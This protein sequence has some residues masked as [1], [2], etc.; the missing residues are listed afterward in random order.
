MHLAWRYIR[1]EGSNTCPGAQGAQRLALLGRF[2]AL[3]ALAVAAS[4]IALGRPVDQ[5]LE[6]LAALRP[7][8][9]RMQRLG[10]CGMP[11]VVV[12]YAHTP[13]ALEQVLCAL[14]PVATQRRGRLICVVGAGGERDTGKR[15]LMG[16][17]AARHADQ[18]C[19]SSDNPRGENP[20]H[21]IAQMLDG[22]RS[23][24]GTG[25]PGSAA[26]ALGSGSVSALDGT[27]DACGAACA[28]RS[29]R[30][31]CEADRAT[32]IDRMLA[33]AAR[34][35]LVLIAGKGHE[36]YQEIGGQRL[37]FDDRKEAIAGLV[38]HW[39]F[40]PAQDAVETAAH[41]RGIVRERRTVAR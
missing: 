27:A 13:D 25:T 33:G 16:A 7:V 14:R 3:N 20:L 4:W 18:V 28:E 32:A 24:E 38:R 2:N 22:A 17:V 1:L 34:E 35:D 8:D 30:I 12:D 23:A 6:A 9:G 5:A 11:L 19:L 36:R 29:A 37:P 26:D 21:I 39:G 15:A 10:G 31:T 41:A 40:L